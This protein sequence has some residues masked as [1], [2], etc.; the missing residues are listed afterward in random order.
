M[1][2]RI[3]QGRL[4]RH[5][6]KKAINTR[7]FKETCSSVIGIPRDL[8]Q[9]PGYVD[10][11]GVIRD[12]GRNISIGVPLELCHG[13]RARSRSIVVHVSQLIYWD[14]STDTNTGRL[15]RVQRVAAARMVFSD[16]RAN[17]GVTPMLQ[18]LQWPDLYEHR[19]QAKCVRMYRIVY[20][21]VNISSFH[22]TLTI[23]LRGHSMK[24]LIP[25]ARTSTY[26]KSFFTDTIRLWNS[27][28]HIVLRC[29][30]IYSFNEVQALRLR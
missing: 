24:F 14:P 12:P 26:Q 11:A 1:H 23:S 18:Q 4:L 29:S 27:L 13:S 22:L 17:R 19:A 10:H 15:E 3:L 6:A 2:Q 7:L 21:L 9:D 20:H 25:Y 16:H 28:P 30:T 5:T 8:L